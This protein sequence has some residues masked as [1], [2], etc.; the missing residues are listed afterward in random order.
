LMIWATLNGAKALGIEHSFGTFE[1][2]KKPGINLVTSID[3]KN[4]KLTKE[5]RVQRLV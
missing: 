3:F 2:G 4:M 5:S 1:S